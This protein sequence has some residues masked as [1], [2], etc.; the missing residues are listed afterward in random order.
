MYMVH[1]MID[2]NHR[3]THYCGYGTCSV[4]FQVAALPMAQLVQHFGERAKYISEC[5]RGVH[6]EPVKVGF[7]EQPPLSML[8]LDLAVSLLSKLGLCP[9]RHD[10]SLRGR[11]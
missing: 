7:F 4:A 9:Q 8:V 2:E 5:V 10:V 11:R 3:S 6:D 1:A